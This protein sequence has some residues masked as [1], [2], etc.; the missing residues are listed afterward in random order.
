L[1]LLANTLFET[2]KR[3]DDKLKGGTLMQQWRSHLWVS[4]SPTKALAD[5]NTLQFPV[6]C[7][8]R[9]SRFADVASRFSQPAFECETLCASLADH[10]KFDQEGWSIWLI[11]WRSFWGAT[12]NIENIV[13]AGAVER[14]VAASTFIRSTLAIQH[15]CNILWYWLFCY[16]YIRVQLY[17]RTSRIWNDLRRKANCLTPKPCR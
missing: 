7:P 13:E 12:E 3:D 5:S 6:S 8:L 10:F 2:N 15:Y 17:A 16:S 11:P 4:L 14:K 1:D 9:S